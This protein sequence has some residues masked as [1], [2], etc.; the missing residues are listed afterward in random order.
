MDCSIWDNHSTPALLELLEFPTRA[1]KSV[2]ML[3]VA[4]LAVLPWTIERRSEATDEAP[5]LAPADWL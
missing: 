2:A 3:L 4:P 5:A 1:N